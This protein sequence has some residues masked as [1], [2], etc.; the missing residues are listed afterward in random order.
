MTEV[1]R[2]E[3][4][5]SPLSATAVVKAPPR[6][7][8][9]C[10]SLSGHVIMFLLLSRTRTRQVPLQEGVCIFALAAVVCVCI[11]CCF[12]CSRVWK[13]MCDGDGQGQV[14]R[15]PFCQPWLWSKL[16]HEV[17]GNVRSRS[18]ISSQVIMTL[19]LSCRVS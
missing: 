10:E 18:S 19:S 11:Y 12:I 5:D 3:S 16:L 13:G 15:L 2:V 4:A 14:R 17:Q 8:G 7:T 1:V 9:E 6:G